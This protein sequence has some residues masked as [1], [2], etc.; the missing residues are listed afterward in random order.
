MEETMFDTV[1]RPMGRHFCWLLAV[2]MMAGAGVRAYG[3]GPAAQ[4][5]PATTTVADTVYLADGTTASGTLI[6]TWPPFVTASGTAVAGGVSQVT[7]GANGALSVALVPNAGATPAGMYYT[8]VYQIGAGAV[9]TEYWIVPTTS[10]VNIAGVV[11][12]P[13][14]GV[15]AQPVSMQYVNTQLAAKANNNAVVHLTGSETITGTKSYS[16]SPNVPTPVNPGD[17]ASKS[18]VDTSVSSVGAGTFLSTAGGTMT[19]PITLPSN[20][21][22]PLQAATKQYVDLG[23]STTAG[24]ISGLV[25]ASELGTG[26]A[27]GA[28]CLLGNGTWGTCGSGGGTGNVSTNPVAGVSQNITQPVGTQFST[29]N[30]AGITYVVASYNWPQAG[31]PTETCTG[32]CVSAALVAGT[33][34]TI[35]L[36]PCPAGIDTSN[37][38]SAQYGVFIFG[39]GTPEAVA[40]T[41]G[42]CTSG[43][44]SGTI[45]F[46]PGNN[47]G[48]GFTVGSASGG[49][50]EAINVAAGS[51]QTHAVI[52]DVPTAGGA[53]SAN[54]NIYWPVFFKTTKGVLNGDGAFWNCYTRSVCLM[55]GNY[56][57]TLGTY[58]VVKGL[59]LQSSVN[60]TGAHIASVSASS[61]IFTAT[62]SSNHNL[63]AGDW[64]ILYYTAPVGTQEARVQVLSTGLSATQFQYQI[65]T[66]T[67]FSASAGFGWV[68]IENA[69]IESE[70][71]GARL[72]NI[73]FNSGVGGGLF[74][75]GVVVGNDQH[76][77]I[78][79]M[80]NQGSGAAFRCDANFCGNLIYIRGDQGAA[81]VP[82]IHHVEASLQ[83]GGN[84]IRN[85]AGNTMDVKDS[86]IQGTSQYSIFYGNGLN[87]WEVDNVYYETGTC[88]NPFYTAG[89]FAA[90]AGFISNTASQ[91]TIQ[92]N[93]PL[94]GG[95]PSFASGGTPTTQRNY[96]VVAH[97][98]NLGVSPLLFIGTAQPASTGTSIPLYWPN[99][100]LTGAGTRTWDVIVTIGGGAATAPYTGNAFSL[101]AGITPACTTAGVCTVTDTQGTQ[102]AYTVA[103]NTWVPSFWFWPAS[104]VLGKGSTM[105]IDE[106]AQAP[107]FAVSSY[108]PSVFAK[109][110]PKLGQPYYY[111]PLWIVCPA[112]DSVGNN[113]PN[114]G[115]HVMQ[116]AAATFMPTGITG[117]LNFNAGP[118]AG[119]SPRQ[120]ITT[121]DGSPQQTFATPGYVRT[122]SAKDSFIGTDSTSVIGAQ[123]Q[124]YGAP[125]GHFFYVN[126]AGTSG[127]TWKLGISPSAATFNT[128]VTF[129]SGLTFAGITGATQCLQVS[130]AGVVSGTG[131]ACGTGGSGGGSMVYP[132]TGIALSSGSGWGSSLAA[133]ASAV[134][135]VSDTQTLSNKS[136][137]TGMTWP[138]FN[139]STTGNAATAT[140][141]AATPTLCPTGQVPTGILANGNATGCAA[142]GGGA[143]TVNSGVAAQVALYSASGAAVS[144]DGTLT[145]NGTMLNYAGSGG[146]TATAGTFTGNLTVNGQLNVAGP[147]MVSSPIPGTAMAAAGAGMSA[148][149]ISN[150]GNLYISAN[151]GTPQKVATTATSSYF[152][153]LTQEDGYD[154]GQFVVGE[155]TANPQNLHVYSSYTSSSAW[156]RTSVGFDTA[157]NYA[158][159]RSESSTAGAAPG[160]GFWINNGLKWVVD[161]SSNL[162]PWADETYNIGTFT[163][164][165]G[166]GLR[167]ATIYAAGSTASNSGFELGKFANNSY[168]LCNDTTNGTVLNGLAVLTTAGCAM[169]PTSAATAGVIGVVIAPLAP[170]TSATTVTL[171][172]TGSA[173]CS[174]DATATVVG[175]YV[176]PSTTANGGA[177][178]LCH[179]AGATLPSGSQ[180]LGRVLQATAGGTTAQMFFDMP[181]SNAGPSA[182]SSVFGRSGT[183]AATSGDYSVAQVTGAAPLASPTFTGTVT[184]PD[185]TTN[186]S[187]GYTFAHALTLPSGSLATTAATGDNSTKVAT[188]A[189]VRGEQYLTYS[190]P[191]ATVGAVEQFCTWT[192][193]AAITVTGFDVS[194][195]TDPV[196]CTTSAVVQVWDGAANT[197]VGSFSVAL[198]NGNNF[199]T[200]VTGST[201]VPSGHALRVK[202]TTGEAGCSTTAA[203]V[204]AIVT[205]QMQN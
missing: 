176:V 43:A 157:D 180:V 179:D 114:I 45:V 35:T 190:C 8:V 95:T 60:V 172:R 100:E 72:E 184:E 27:N 80:T 123:D 150:D 131:A 88:T 92:G 101:F 109:R 102:T 146:I 197:E 183:V 18:Y 151:A 16:V 33:Q 134:V 195:G 10:P 26:T 76:F 170:G 149:G 166:L 55:V 73:K 186:A 42:S 31:S 144:G 78:E 53:N 21:A 105:Y 96:F 135:G 119:V 202:T 137:G 82:Y 133:P 94:G 57:G 106:A 200:Q 77:Q 46:T 58:S 24:L 79:G 185:G 161:A 112:G 156:Q 148:V 103:S 12:T 25:P 6:I 47:H 64:V 182:V 37:T 115:A 138:T 98:T 40:V 140:A 110:C 160:L 7:L 130:T 199:Y 142:G 122:G 204:V 173:F 44:S 4:S 203:N 3:T 87:P 164:S 154:V 125:G 132:G 99:L 192:L 13:G 111:A 67:T 22:A 169:K 162:K 28:T 66:T 174:F 50:Q 71:D 153:N 93:A 51:G 141:L 84:G 70:T 120:I 20:P 113:N 168:E 34:A 104:V 143:G 29:N 193:P 36:T 196:G 17:V 147:W 91:F 155:T 152:T 68:A 128:P 97:D 81:A 90:E 89:S 61:G 11:T 62:T 108:L 69:G 136:F 32:G 5:G 189:Y 167:P 187:S 201:N 194:A 56:T 191:V 139:Q 175:D 165:T 14:S 59:E 1:R 41:G 188:T 145:D 178:P 177:Y 63:V 83:C 9:K 121:L 65:G 107:L 15:A 117:A 118:A 129:S 85:L 2:V 124:T 126:D 86:V 205:Y 52:Q 54:Y 49:N 116:I 75:Q 159:F 30:L 74:H 127:T 23:L 163:A 171:V 19:G 39:T 38:A 181:G 158:V 48:A 198:S